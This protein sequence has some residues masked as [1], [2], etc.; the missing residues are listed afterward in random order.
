MIGLDRVKPLA[1]LI[2]AESA[3]M[4]LRIQV[5]GP[6]CDVMPCRHAV[7]AIGR[8]QFGSLFWQSLLGLELAGLTRVFVQHVTSACL[9]VKA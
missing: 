4:T 2:I 5:E 8:P 9:S 1:Q 6:A 7:C 3:T